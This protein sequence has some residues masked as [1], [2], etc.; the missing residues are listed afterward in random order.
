MGSDPS[1]VAGVGLAATLASFFIGL[2][3]ALGILALL[4]LGD[5]RGVNR[6]TLVV[7]A[8]SFAIA[9][10]AWVFVLAARNNLGLP[11][12]QWYA[13]SGLSFGLLGGLFPR[14]VGIPVVTLAVLA[15]LLCAAE[16]TSWHRWQDGLLIVEL[17]IFAADED[18]TLCGLTTA[19]RNSVPV[20]QN[21]HLAPGPLVLEV[22]TLSI[23]GPLAFIFG[24][25]H[26]RL[27]SLG[28][29]ANGAVE[30]APSGSADGTQGL[31][32]DAVPSIHLFP[33]KPGVLEA[34]GAGSPLLVYLGISR[35]GLRSEPL[36]AEDLAQGNYILQADG[37]LTSEFR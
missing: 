13:L 21:L 4:R 35:T 15:V 25:R 12:L 10:G 32:A 28:V 23:A 11:E 9:A 18:S 19:E 17:K 20:F 36:P 5:G 6:V 24:Y 33:F 1:F 34:G 37:S 30:R 8:S 27:S 14:F 22:D 26:Y 3:L 7:V 31:A 2:V 29:E 16:L